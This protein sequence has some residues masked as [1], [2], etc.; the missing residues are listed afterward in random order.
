MIS[1]AT[2]TPLVVSGAI[3]FGRKGRGAQKVIHT[4]PAPTPPA[5]G[6]VTR[7]A[8]LMALAIHFDQLV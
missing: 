4:G 1:Q 2:S 6:R 7:V 3:H 5:P 8:R